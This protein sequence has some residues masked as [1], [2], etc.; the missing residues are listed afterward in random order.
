MAPFTPNSLPVLIG[1]L[2]MR[3]HE[4][5][6]RLV[7]DHTPEIPL[8]VQLPQYPE[9]G[10]VN[11]FLP[12]MPGITRTAEKIFIDT[13]SERYEQDLPRFYEDYLAVTENAALL[14]KSRFALTDQTARGFFVFSDIIARLP[15][16]PAAVKG[17]V[18]GPITM[19]I[20]VKDQN[21][22]SIFYD[23][24]LRDVVVKHIAMKARW[25]V[26]QLSR[27]GA[28][29]I[30]FFDEPGI[31]SFGTSAF[32][33]ISREQIQ[34]VISEAI[35]A[36]HAANGLVGIHICAN[37]DWSLALESET[38]IISFDAYSYFDRFVLYTDQIKQFVTSGRILAWG[39]VP[40][41]DPEDV[42]RE[43]VSSLYERWQEQARQ[44]RAIT[45]LEQ[46][47]LT[48]QTLITP[49]CGTGSLRLDQATKVL[50]LTKGV[51]EKIRSR[52]CAP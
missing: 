8:W 1:S 5:A 21:G 52:M 14:K 37:G 24:T 48:A 6:T 20:G 42:E 30:L 25:Q 10:M 47:L 9:E 11:Q 7:L 33:S 50:E 46:D 4:A 13:S 23:E 41:S 40:T 19:G 29:P 38:D 27:L 51:S 12:G 49:S 45:G 26:E 22:R 39:I 17:Q 2:P 3:D 36:V 15:R 44:L 32:I 16:P 31:V 35:D 43:T 18:T 34:A 28:P